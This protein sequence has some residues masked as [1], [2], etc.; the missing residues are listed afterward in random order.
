MTTQNNHPTYVW[1]VCGN[2]LRFFPLFGFWSGRGG[3]SLGLV[4][5]LLML[6]FTLWSSN[7]DVFERCFYFFSILTTQNDHPAYVKHILGGIYVF[8]TLFGHWVCV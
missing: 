4:Q 6:F 8:F 2:I 7:I 5:N 1:Y 3:S